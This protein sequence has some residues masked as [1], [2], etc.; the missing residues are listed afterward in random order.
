MYIKDR[1]LEELAME[2]L[3]FPVN[4]VDKGSRKKSSFSIGPAAKGGGDK[5]LATMKK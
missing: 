5:G 1:W 2:I 4:K 3:R